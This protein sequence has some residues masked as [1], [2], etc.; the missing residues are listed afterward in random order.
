MS[1]CAPVTCSTHPAG[2]SARPSACPARRRCTSRSTG[3]RNTWADYLGLLPRAVE[4]AASEDSAFRESLP[5]GYLSN[6]GAHVDKKCEA[7]KRSSA[8]ASS[9]SWRGSLPK[10]TCRCTPQR[11]AWRCAS[12]TGAS[13]ARA[14]AP[15]G[16]TPPRRPTD[17][18][19][20]VHRARRAGVRATRHGGRRRDALLL[21]RQL[22]CTWRRRSRRCLSRPL[23]PA[24][25]K[26]IDSYPRY[27][28]VGSLE[29]L[30]RKSKLLSQTFCSR[31]EL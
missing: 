26:L 4:F 8:T 9:H 30:S 5:R 24:L 12:C 29:G 28:R 13:A 19:D 15:P 27:V 7:R 31:R 18:P 25:E 22:S 1:F 14:R 20:H 23:R 3:Q 21:H 10:S 11:T 2:P 16:D 6:M 17:Q